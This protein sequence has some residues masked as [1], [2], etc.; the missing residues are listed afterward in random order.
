LRKPGA[1]ARETPED[2][3]AKSMSTLLDLTRRMEALK[4][5]C[6]EPFPYFPEAS[7]KRSSQ[8]N[9]GEAV[10]RWIGLRR[11]GPGQF[12]WAPRWVPNV[13]AKSTIYKARVLSV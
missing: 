12:Y 6:L 11:C 9:H 4:A 1:S 10:K 7:V 8:V 5:I 2:V 3:G 13:L